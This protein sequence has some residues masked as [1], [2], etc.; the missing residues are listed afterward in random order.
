MKK[1]CLSVLILLLL[2]SVFTQDR[3]AGNEIFER[4]LPRVGQ[5]YVPGEFIVKFKSSVT[6]QTIASINSTH[7]VSTIYTSPSIG[8][9]RLRVPGGMTVAEMVEIY[10]ANTNVEY[11]EANYIAYALKSANDELYSLQWHLYNTQYG[12]IQIESAWDIS[13]G[14]GVVVAILDTGIAYEDYYEEDSTGTARQY[15]QAPDLADT[16]FVNGYDFVN[17]DEHPND[18]SY[19]GHGTHIAGTIAQ[20]LITSS[21]RLE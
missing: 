10:L 21:E 8:F 16:Y 4:G 9:R 1:L 12:G 2:S 19:S 13:T 6:Q 15:Q 3:A 17:R 5:M 11:A 7:G 18:D 20:I 14:S